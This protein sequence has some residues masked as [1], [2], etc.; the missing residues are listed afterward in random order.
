MS[1]IILKAIGWL[2]RKFGLLLL[3]IIALL[4]APSVKD[5]WRVLED[6]QPEA[7]I[8]DVANQTQE[9]APDKNSSV[10]VIKDR[11]AKKKAERVQLAQTQ[12]ILPTCTLVK[13]SNIYRA[14]VEIEIIAQALSYVEAV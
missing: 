13:E 2:S 5:A 11:L 1:K 6:F 9:T 12:C 4:L 7:I 8:K 14:D 10:Q 3:L